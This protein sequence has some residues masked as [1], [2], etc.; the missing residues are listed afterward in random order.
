MPTKHTIV[1]ILLSL[2]LLVY[3]PAGFGQQP[4]TPLTDSIQT[5]ASRVLSGSSEA[6]R[7][8]ADSS[9]NSLLNK[10]L[11]EATDFSKP[12]PLPPSIAV[13][14]P[15]D[16]K[17]RLIN[18]AIPLNHGKYAYRLLMQ[19]HDATST[20]LISL[21]D[22]SAVVATEKVIHHGD[23]WFGALYYKVIE[24]KHR[25]KVI[26]TLL[27]WNRSAEGFQTKLAEPV[28]FDAQQNLPTFGARIFPGG[29]SRYLVKYSA[30]ASLSMRYSTQSL[31]V[32]LGI[33]N[34]LKT[35]TEEMVVFDRVTSNDV[36]FK[37]DPRFS[38]PAGNIFDALFW[39][40][41]R[42]ALLRDI[43][44]RNEARPADD[45][46]RPNDLDLK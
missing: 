31:T 37:T 12:L 35:I 34:R 33:F 30:K 7:L 38:Y 40:K 39:E 44:A 45:L 14:V 19:Y 25:R 9:L 20:N 32:R 8:R 5:L 43:D 17:F 42:W 41:G 15:A 6:D 22:Q 28:T 27:G 29:A 13:V 46:P 2:N 23:Q 3:L 11:K 1:S 4:S 16:L 24:K 21:S 36:R 18:W 26:Y 10:L